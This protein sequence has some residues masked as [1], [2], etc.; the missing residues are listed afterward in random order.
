MNGNG[1]GVVLGCL[2]AADGLEFKEVGFWGLVG[3]GKGST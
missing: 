3:E 2:F 1:N